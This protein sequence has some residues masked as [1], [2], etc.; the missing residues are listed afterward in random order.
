MPSPEFE[1][2]RYE[3]ADHVATITFAR[4]KVMNAFRAKTLH[5]F[6]AALDAVD[7]DD[8]VRAIVVTGEGKAF[9]AGADISLGADAFAPTQ[10]RER[11]GT[12]GTAPAEPPRDGGGMIAL[13]IHALSKPIIA[14]VN[15][16]AVGMGATMTLPMDVRVASTNARYGFPFVRRGI[17]PEGCSSWFLP[18][19]VGIGVASEWMLTGRLVSADEA[20]GAGLVHS[21][22]API[23]VLPAAYAIARE[24]S[25][26]AAPVSVAMTRQLLHRMLTEPDP[27]T[28]HLAET[29]GHCT[30]FAFGRRPRRG[31]VVPRQ[32]RTELHGST[33]H[34]GH[35]HLRVNPL[36]TA[37]T[38]RP[39][40]GGGHDPF[41]ISARWTALAARPSRA[42]CC[43]TAAT[44]PAATSASTSSSRSPAS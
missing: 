21:L 41:P 19:V 8:D 30:T 11:A 4:P 40:T 31:G 33:Q 29:R 16:A 23:E 13:R 27:M 37:G 1:D 14:A 20:L 5:E 10:S 9:C 38:V 39:W 28:A 2:L 43:S 36:H 25:D 12:S 18:R 35:R 42:C 3:V 32:A 6:L 24:I 22:H 44:S 15:G 17:I 34:D 7:A 26:N